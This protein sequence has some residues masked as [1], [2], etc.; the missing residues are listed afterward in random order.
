MTVYLK[1]VTG[2]M[3]VPGACWP[4]LIGELLGSTRDPVSTVE[5]RDTEENQGG[6]SCGILEQ[7]TRGKLR[8]SM[9]KSDER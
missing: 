5:V 4:Y 9:G 2:D 6:M 7:D 1:R 3:R 8:L